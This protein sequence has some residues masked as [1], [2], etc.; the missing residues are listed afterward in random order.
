MIGLGFVPILG[1]T[2]IGTLLQPQTTW[3]PMV[4]PVFNSFASLTPDQAPPGPKGA[5]QQLNIGGKL[6]AANVE[7]NTA[8]DVRQPVLSDGCAGCKATGWPKLLEV[9]TFEPRFECLKK[10]KE[11]LLAM[12][13]RK[14]LQPLMNYL[15]EV[16]VHYCRLSSLERLVTIGIAPHILMTAWIMVLFPGFEDL[17]ISRVLGRRCANWLHFVD[18]CKELPILQPKCFAWLKSRL[19][20]TNCPNLDEWRKKLNLSFLCKAQRLICWILLGPRC[21]ILGWGE[22]AAACWA[23]LLFVAKDWVECRGGDEQQS[24]SKSGSRHL[25]AWW[26]YYNSSVTLG[27]QCQTFLWVADNSLREQDFCEGPVALGGSAER[28]GGTSEEDSNV[29][30]YGPLLAEDSVTWADCKQSIG[31]F[32]CIGNTV[33][34]REQFALGHR[35][36]WSCRQEERWS[37]T[38]ALRAADAK[39]D[40]E[41]STR[42]PRWKSSGP[43]DAERTLLGQ[44]LLWG[45]WCHE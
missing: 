20:I 18:V 33:K 38:W 22:K 8:N 21:R 14:R 36:S 44:A 28:S 35:R 3:E 27:H 13:Q 43:A 32:R 7:L 4:A 6:E 2:S 11:I 34:A 39:E 15:Q 30:I 17:S 45:I 29:A 12:R 19:R 26:W 37:L 16:S 5:A 41:N 9:S 40:F 24:C 1:D 23:G 25:A 31:H 10:G 42:A